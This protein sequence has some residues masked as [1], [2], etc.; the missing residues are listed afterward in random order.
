MRLYQKLASLIVAM[1]NCQKS[2]NVEW[3]NTH[4]HNAETLVRSHMPH[5]S[6]FDSG[7]YL[8]VE[9]C[10]EDKLVFT[11]DYHHMDEHGMYGAWTAHKVTVR[12][13]L[14]FDFHLGISGR[15]PNDV[16][17]YIHEVFRTALNTEVAV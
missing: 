17:D 6:G 14:A 11:T 2:G 15:N 7:T 16:K 12:P 4:K 8:R 1:R 13:S 5:G 10:T 9:E 3:Y